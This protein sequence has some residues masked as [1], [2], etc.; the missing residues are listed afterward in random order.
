MLRALAVSTN[1]FRATHEKAAPGYQTEHEFGLRVGEEGHVVGLGATLVVLDALER[2]N[3]FLVRDGVFT[4]ALIDLWVRLKRENE[5]NFISL[6]PHP[7]EFMLYF[8]A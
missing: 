1:P 8:D 5:V 4:E 6:R 7:S 3:E 2:D